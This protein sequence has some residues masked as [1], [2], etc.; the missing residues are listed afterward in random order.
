[1][2]NAS[3]LR[4][5]NWLL[6]GNGNYYKVEVPDLALLLSRPDTKECNPI[7]LTPEVLEKCGGKY[8]H[9]DIGC[10]DPKDA[11]WIVG[12]MNFAIDNL[13]WRVQGLNVTLKS[14]HQL[15]NIY[16]CLCGNELSIN[17]PL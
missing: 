8:H 16:W 13:S 15:Q 17:L 14:L 5:G 10:E 11:Y 4:I 2:V 1:M 7:L 6:D 3:E 12:E 9:L